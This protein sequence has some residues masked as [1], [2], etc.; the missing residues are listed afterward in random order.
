[1]T[2]Y[3]EIADVG[4]RD[5]VKRRDTCPDAADMTGEW[6]EEEVVDNDAN[7]VQR[8]TEQDG[9]W[10]EN[11]RGS[12]AL[13]QSRRG[14]SADSRASLQSIWFVRRAILIQVRCC[15]A[16][17]FAVPLFEAEAQISVRQITR[18]TRELMKPATGD[19]TFVR[20][21]SVTHEAPASR[22]GAHRAKP[23]APLLA[24]ISL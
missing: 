7:A 3:G 22:K 17:R 18:T 12:H 13:S 2:I 10:R 19:T 15:Q 11:C 20:L 23:L 1:M 24:S 8:D 14:V 5:G 9:G 4:M 16:G 21:A 6:V